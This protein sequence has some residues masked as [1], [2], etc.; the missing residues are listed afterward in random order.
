MLFTLI[1]RPEPDVAAGG[2]DVIRMIVSD[3]GVVNWEPLVRGCDRF[4]RVKL[5]IVAAKE[6]AGLQLIDRRCPNAV[7]AL[8]NVLRSAALQIKMLATMCFPYS[9][10]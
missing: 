6:I 10:F 1:M 7:R 3:A 2:A 8:G 5:P 4:D 9:G